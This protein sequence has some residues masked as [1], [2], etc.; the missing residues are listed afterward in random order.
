MSAVTAGDIAKISLLTGLSEDERMVVANSLK[1]RNFSENKV[2]FKEGDKGGVIYFLISGEV[3]ISQSLT[4]SMNKSA[5]YD[6]REKSIIQL[7]SEDGPVFGEVSIFGK[8]DKR[9]A[10]VT[11]LTECRMGLL[12]EKDFFNLLVADHE[13]GYKIMLN[14]TRIVCERLVGAN[15]NVLKLT[16]ALSLILE[17]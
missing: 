6:T 8:E 1:L 4:L 2:I 13:I 5:S 10:T 11:A 9:S 12:E 15:Q 17:R 14:L 16:T 7:S 3:M